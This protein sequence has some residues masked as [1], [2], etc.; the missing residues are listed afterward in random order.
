MKNWI[1][2]TIIA[3][4]I[5]FYIGSLATKE[6]KKVNVKNQNAVNSYT[7]AINNLIESELGQ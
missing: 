4:V 1:I 2:G 6:V 7:Q 5:C 3:G